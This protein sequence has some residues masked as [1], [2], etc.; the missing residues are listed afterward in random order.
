MS[1][2]NEFEDPAMSEE[3]AETKSHTPEK[4]GFGFIVAQTVT[5]STP[6]PEIAKSINNFF[7]EMG[8]ELAK[9]CHIKRAAIETGIHY[10]GRKRILE[11][12]CYI[13]KA[14]NENVID[15]LYYLGKAIWRGQ[16][17][18][19]HSFSLFTVDESDRMD[20]NGEREGISL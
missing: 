10:N 5:E 2:E 6:L 16:P 8:S 9:T 15:R 7:N 19:P 18:E 4:K 13:P 17:T 20:G 12:Q 14:T 3:G 1:T 11:G